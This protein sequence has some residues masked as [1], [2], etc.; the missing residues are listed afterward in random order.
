[1]HKAQRMHREWLCCGSKAPKLQPQNGMG[2]SDGEA[3][4]S[5]SCK[6]AL[7]IRCVNKTAGS[8]QVNMGGRRSCKWGR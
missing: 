6:P 7:N 3:L 2:G 8:A 5:E 4:I 1:M